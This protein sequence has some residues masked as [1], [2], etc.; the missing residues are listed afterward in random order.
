MMDEY[1]AIPAIHARQNIDFGLYN[2]QDHDIPHSS[3]A[4]SAGDNSEGIFVT[5]IAGLT[6]Y[7][8]KQVSI[9]HQILIR[10]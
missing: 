3:G 10:I 6:M 9:V 7:S 5:C 4:A 2:P 1:I 8:A